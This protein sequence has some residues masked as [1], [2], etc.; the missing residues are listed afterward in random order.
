MTE[1]LDLCK[2]CGGKCCTHPWM[3]DEE[4]IRLV[5]VIGNE[6]AQAGRPF[7]VNGGWVWR[8]NEGEKCPGL[9]ETGC[10]LPHDERPRNCQLYP[11]VMLQIVT[12]EIK[13]DILPVLDIHICPHWVEF[14][15]QYESIKKEIEDVR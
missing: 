6:K 8:L 2:Q 12:K 1:I 7:R 9:T 15:K 4:Y 3:S 5:L 10:A 13:R 14:G 11:F